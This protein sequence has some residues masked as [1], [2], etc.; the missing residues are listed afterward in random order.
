[1]IDMTGPK[2]PDGRKRGTLQSGHSGPTQH[3]PAASPLLP[4]VVMPELLGAA[5]A[6]GGKSCRPGLLQCRDCRGQFTV[7]TRTPLHGTKLDRRI[8]ICAMFLVLTSSK[9]I[10]SVVMARLLG[11][12]Q[13]TAWMLGH[14]IREMMDEGHGELMP[15]EE[16]VEVDDGYVGGAPKS[17]KQDYNPPGRGTRKLMVFVAASRDG[18][19]RAKVVP[20]G[21]GKTLDAVL[22]TWI[23]RE[24]TTLMTDGLP[25]QTGIGET[26]AE[27]HKV[28]HKNKEYTNP[29]TGAHVNTAEA[30]MSN[31][32]R[33][34]GGV[35]HDLGRK[36]LQ[37]YLDEIIWRWN[38]RE[39]EREIIKEWTTKG[40]EER[41]KRITI[42]KPVPVVPQ[43]R[44]LL[45]GVVGKQMRR[46]QNYGL[47]WP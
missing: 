26:T 33:A 5:V 7:T 1:M 16:E 46:S 22:E 35:C 47:C 18:Q 27:H 31:V 14:R 9:G 15:L 30:V 10:S 45:Q 39:P 21:T 44:L 34:L 13:K 38:H 12:N 17:L 40:G 2:L 11:V 32:Q 19:G 28:I 4:V 29:E 41:E 36:H 23:V 37:R 8:W 6:K 20:G 42:W 3:A 25:V 24:N 43:M